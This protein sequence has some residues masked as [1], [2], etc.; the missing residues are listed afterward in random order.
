MNHQNEELKFFYSKSLTFICRLTLLALIIGISYIISRPSYNFSHWIPH[1]FIHRIGV[2]YDTILWAEQHADMALHF[3]GGLLISLLI[4]ASNL[5][6]FKA[7][8][9]RVFLIV[10]IFCL[11]AEVL[12]HII[13]RGFDYLDLLLGILGSFMAYLAINKNN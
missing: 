6:F 2:P 10:F 12:Q 11:A 4:Y 5:P 1:N 13:G 3:F 9:M 7:N 8:G